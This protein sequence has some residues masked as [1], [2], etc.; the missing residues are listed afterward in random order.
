MNSLFGLRGKGFTVVASD[1]T[2]SESVITLL[3]EDRK[4]Y[5][6]WDRVSIGYS[7]DQ[8]SVRQLLSYAREKM[9]FESLRNSVP[10]TAEVAAHVI[11]KTVHASLRGDPYKA[12]CLVADKDVL[13]AVD[14][15]GAM[16]KA[17][18]ACMGYA[19]YFLYG[20][21]DKEW[22]SSISLDQAMGLVQKC[23]VALKDRFVLGTTN[24]SVKIV[25]EKGIEERVVKAS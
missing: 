5:A 14:M 22:N 1:L 10:V 12:G 25:S 4:H 18:Y 16:W 11:Q 3:H 17:D 21:L 9:K 24:Y 2:L 20:I 6:V 23:V 7:G 15:Y 13:F 8:G 19:Q